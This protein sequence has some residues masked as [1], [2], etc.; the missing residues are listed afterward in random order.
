MNPTAERDSITKLAASDWR[1]AAEIAAGISDPWF[2]CQALSKAA[3][4]APD[5]KH[6]LL[7]INKALDSGAECSDPNRIGTVSSWPVK[8][9]YMLG[10]LDEGDKVSVGLLEVILTEESP[11]RR[12]DALNYLL[13]AVLAGSMSTFWCVFDAFLTACITKLDSGKK[14][15]KGESLLASWAGTISLLDVHRGDLLLAAIEG[16]DHRKQADQ[17]RERAQYKTTSELITWPNI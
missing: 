16:P 1:K 6:Q 10:Y 7:L 5:K 4:L 12:A 15:S 3:L 2:R 9:L 14:N 13:G 11:V 17:S 8:A